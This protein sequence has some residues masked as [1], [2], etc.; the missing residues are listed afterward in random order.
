MV[1]H[2]RRRN[3]HRQLRRT[4]TST[5]NTHRSRP[6]STNVNAVGPMDGSGRAWSGRPRVSRNVR[7]ISASQLRRVTRSMAWSAVWAKSIWADRGITTVINSF[8]EAPS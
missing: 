7:R 5:V 4:P 8:M 3:A 1:V 6:N 2:L